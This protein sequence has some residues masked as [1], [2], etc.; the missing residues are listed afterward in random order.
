MKE[1]L[2]NI[3]LNMPEDKIEYW[4]TFIKTMEESG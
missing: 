4:L 2:I 1:E 3:I